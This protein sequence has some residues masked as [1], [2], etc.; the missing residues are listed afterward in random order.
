MSLGIGKG[1]PRTVDNEPR[2]TLVLNP[3]RFKSILYFADDDLYLEFKVWERGS[4]GIEELQQFLVSD[5]R[6]ALSDIF[7][8]FIILFTPISEVPSNLQS[9]YF[10]KIHSRSSQTTTPTS[11]K[12][13]SRS[14]TPVSSTPYPRLV[15]KKFLSEPATPAELRA[16][17][18][19]V[20]L[21]NRSLNEIPVK[22][23][24]SR[25]SSKESPREVA[26]KSQLETI[27][28]IERTYE[29]L[30]EY[31]PLN[32]SENRSSSTRKSDSDEASVRETVSS[33]SDSHV[34]SVREVERLLPAVENTLSSPY[35]TL[36]DKEVEE[37]FSSTVTE[38]DDSGKDASDRKEPT[39]KEIERRKRYENEARRVR[40]RFER[41]EV[42]VLH[43]W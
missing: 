18:P 2:I 12:N 8:E 22:E 16:R 23:P 17:S 34:V 40:R 38:T 41:G 37:S 33:T 42:G 30:E 31:F 9:F 25:K 11:L 5:V 6:K 13:N 20:F 29:T 14:T 27:D 24:L 28:N 15:M 3:G 1:T 36:T 26:K 10:S 7:L 32:P 35:D 4:I 39:W 21:R 43:P 19:V